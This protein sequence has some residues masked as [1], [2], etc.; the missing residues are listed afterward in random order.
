MSR[1]F[2]FDFGQNDDIDEDNSTE[3]DQYHEAANQQQED[4]RI[5][6]CL[7]TLDDLLST[8]LSTISYN[9][10]TIQSPGH[11]NITLARRELFD[12]RAQLM[13]ED[14]GLDDS[15]TAGL[16]TDDIKP[17]I[18]EGGFKTWECSV[19]LTNYLASHNK[20]L[21]QHLSGP[22]TII[23]L[24]AGTALPSLLLFHLLLSGPSSTSPP[25]RTFVLADFNPS[26]LQLATI[27]NILLTWARASNLISSE[28]GDLDITS[29]VLLSFRQAL[30]ERNV[31]IRALS[32]SWGS[33]FS[34]QAI[35]ESAEG[36]EDVLI[37]ASE[38]IYSPKSTLAF[39]ETLLDLMRKS[40][41]GGGRATALV[42]AKKVYFGVGGGVD[43]FLYVMKELG[44]AG[45]IVW[46]TEGM[47]SGVG[48]CILEVTSTT[49]RTDYQ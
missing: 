35:P 11:G 37:L 4:A 27:P 10:F 30:T 36:L 31:V 48:R 32:G 18:Y 45:E 1:P 38:T 26:V 13:A 43:E 29:D 44:G 3:N 24:G 6:P 15:S 19:D 9:T 5:M 28:P 39:T 7:H 22:C 2:R 17:N 8:L 47:G 16:S 20:D 41:E 42:A 14:T 46:S 23:E 12:I 25:R 21:L 49:E 33:E 40:Q 34:S